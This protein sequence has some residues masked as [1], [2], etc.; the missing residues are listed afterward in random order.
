MKPANT[1]PPMIASVIVTHT[2]I[3]SGERSDMRL[4]R[5]DGPGPGAT[6]AIGGGSGVAP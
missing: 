5:G 2:A 3:I 4:V 6:V 1:P